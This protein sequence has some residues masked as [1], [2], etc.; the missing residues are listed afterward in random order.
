MDNKPVA[1]IPFLFNQ[2]AAA[3]FLHSR[4]QELAA[5]ENPDVV[6]VS[7]DLPDGERARACL[8]GNRT[9]TGSLTITL[10]DEDGGEPATATMTFPCPVHGV[11]VFRSETSI[12][13]RAERWIW[14]PRLVGRPGIWR[15]RPR[16]G[17]EDFYKGKFIVRAVYADGSSYDFPF[18][19]Q[20]RTPETILKKLAA[21]PR[22][23]ENLR[24]L[25][26]YKEEL[27]SNDEELLTTFKQFLAELE[28]ADRRNYIDTATAR[29]TFNSFLSDLKAASSF[30]K[31]DVLAALNLYLDD[32]KPAESDPGTQKENIDVVAAFYLTGKFLKQKEPV[33]WW[34]PCD[35]ALDEED[36][37]WHRLDI[38]AAYLVRRVLIAWK[39]QRDRL[40][41]AAPI[42]EE[43]GPE[44]PAAVFRAVLAG[45]DGAK[46]VGLRTRRGLQRQGQLHYF[47]PLNALDAAAALTAFQ[48][49]NFRAAVLEQLPASWRQNHPS[50]AGFICPV[51]TPE[52][53]R[54]GITL[55][56]AR[57]VVADALGRLHRAGRDGADDVFK[58]KALGYGA[59]LVPFYQH[60][61]GPRSMMGAKNLKQA[62]P[63]AEMAPPAVSTGG[64]E[65]VSGLIKPLVEAGLVPKHAQP[66]P[67]IDL[68]VAY[69]PWY[70]WNMED[71]I[72]ASRRLVDEKI[73]DWEEEEV[74]CRHLRPGFRP[75]APDFTGGTLEQAFLELRYDEKSY[76]FRP[77]PI[78]PEMPVAFFRDSAIG[79]GK[80]PILCGGDEPG[81]LVEI[82]YTP[83]AHPWLGGFLKWKI[84]RLAPLKV[85]DKLMGRYGNKGVVS[86]I[87]DP[88]EMPRLPD[89]ERL[90]AELRGRPVD[91]LLNPHGVISRMNLGQLLETQLG[92]AR[93]LFPD[94]AADFDLSDAN[95]AD[96]G[97]AG[98]GRAFSPRGAEL[99]RELGPRFRDFGGEEP[100]FDEWGRLRLELPPAAGGRRP[101]TEAPVTV[102]FQHIVRLRHTADRKA[103]V[104]GGPRPG[105]RNLY[106]LLTGQPVGGRRRRG[107]Q[108][109]GEMEIWAL[110]AHRAYRT[111]GTVLGEK[112]DPGRAAGKAPWG[113]TFQ[114][115]ADHL[116]A[117][118][119]EID[120]PEP[121]NGPLRLRPL[122]P[123]RL[124]QKSR[125]ITETKT[126]QLGAAGE[127]ACRESGCGY[128]YRGPV[129][130]TGKRQRQG[131]M[132]LTFADLLRDH[133]WR[134]ADKQQSV[135]PA[136][137]AAPGRGGRLSSPMEGEIRLKLEPVGSGGRRQGKR[138]AVRYKRQK[139]SL[140]LDLTLDRKRYHLYKQ[141][142]K[143]G[144]LPPARLLGFPVTCPRHKTTSLAAPKQ[145]H[146]LLPRAGGLADREIFGNLEVENYDLGS[147]GHLELPAALFRD[148]DE[149]RPE[150]KALLNRHFLWRCLRRQALDEKNH[151][152]QTCLLPILPLKY[153]FQRPVLAGGRPREQDR[154]GQVY[155]E[156]V[157]LTRDPNPEPEQLEKIR[158]ALSKLSFLL[159]QR[160]FGKFGLLR[161]DGLGR[162]V[163]FSGRLV[164]VPDPELAWDECCVPT[165]VL[166]VLLGQRLAGAQDFLE[167][168]LADNEQMTK[169]AAELF[170][171]AGKGDDYS[172]A[173]LKEVLGG[174]YW[175]E[176]VSLD[177]KQ[178]ASHLEL[179]FEV[180]TAYLEQNPTWVLLNRQPSLHRYSLMGFRP[181]PL[182]PEEG[183]VLKINP[184]VCKGFGADFDGDE[185]TIHLPLTPEEE[186]EAEAMAPTRKEHLRSWADGQPLANFDQ[187]FVSGHFYLSLQEVGQRKLA[188]LLPSDCEDCRRFLAA[189]PPWTREYGRELLA[190]LCDRHPDKVAEIVPRWMR[191][192]FAAIS[193]GG[194]SFGFLELEK[195]AAG[196]KD[197]MEELRR[198]AENLQQNGTADDDELKQELQEI[199]WKAGEEVLAA[200]EKIAAGFQVSIDACGFG[201]AALAVS[202]ARGRKQTRQLVGLRGLLDP[203]VLPFAAR[204]GEFFIG[205]NLVAGMPPGEAFP[206]AMNGRSSMLDKKLGTGVAGYLTRLL[207]L[208]LWEWVVREGDCGN[209]AG[210]RRPDTCKWHER[211]EICSAC[212]G[213]WP[214]CASP[215]DG[216]PAGLLAAQSF[217]ERGT[218]LSMQSFHT[219]EKQISARE[220]LSLMNG[221]DP[222]SLF[223]KWSW[224]KYEGL[225]D[226]F[227][228]RIREAGAYESL[229]ERHL[230]L[231]WRAVYD[232]SLLGS[233]TRWNNGLRLA[234]ES[235]WPLAGLVGP[236][237]RAALDDA[238]DREE[239]LYSPLSRF[240]LGR[241]PVARRPETHN[242]NRED[243]Q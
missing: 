51:D 46:L 117:L 202:G 139:R 114:A 186:A 69:L 198:Q 101:L 38:F 224:F 220:I 103:Q 12:A 13:G 53:K 86:R 179:A 236:N 162:R 158:P 31:D 80:H 95:A 173:V 144:E 10:R 3:R 105:S 227:I 233:S 211:R 30:Q 34:E 145:R 152:R 89:D 64:E 238:L 188:E 87:L 222:R 65:A 45:L 75:C 4:L 28:A 36:L 204:S 240:L 77:G 213:S 1:A 43:N 183:L 33:T 182:P 150:D 223:G 167:N 118:G 56:L 180:L 22:H 239:H 190:H 196:L 9:L 59:S 19:F 6:K 7:F 164:I 191:L 154:L 127:F 123:E 125:R 133:G 40:R 90:P 54:V 83:P 147:G 15:L 146:F 47:S 207:V 216:F 161:R 106:N 209:A 142:D 237:Q 219:A 48:R 55:H 14:H 136:Y 120:W 79:G 195:I 111:L 206:A 115:I 88:K 78:R 84:R 11:F 203:G 169:L 73:L 143:A 97:R 63:I 235:A 243:E 82:S 20:Q 159:D 184:L 151:E 232:G 37:G 155:Q 102:G 92:L 124:E 49:F 201:F 119:V 160:L 35:L 121:E 25:A 99:L 52:S 41:R 8:E 68:L 5:L 168:F 130:A 215:P 187:D 27:E 128:R 85:G 50:F 96:G 228:S 62:V 149:K 18:C 176:I 199:T 91:L 165:E 116:L 129:A 67:G 197:D 2:E 229:D 44:G 60:N 171:A 122:D 72:V 21:A 126:W 42:N 26:A 137:T 200:L 98:I 189:D 221:R 141:V 76:L 175:R 110:A 104:R 39:K 29:T 132:V 163:D 74:F 112:S 172:P 231:I 242:D 100:L 93:R 131:Q 61:D 58:A 57:G 23:L 208:V 148:L 230:R 113:Q 234:L 135:I 109:L 108:R 174:A 177:Q 134:L 138:L 226:G 24:L 107:G 194:L 210:E 153:R 214:G 170:P 70:G 16:P 193:E 140:H 94:L 66:V 32:L 17:S 166:M 225:V 71:A 181:V 156:L 192:A 185:M 205:A 217:G 218:Q 241:V 178:R 81:E 212:Y 157:K